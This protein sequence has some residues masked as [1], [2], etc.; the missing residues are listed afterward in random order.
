M[1][2]GQVLVAFPRHHSAIVKPMKFPPTIP[3]AAHTLQ[4]GILSFVSQPRMKQCAPS[5]VHQ[6]SVTSPF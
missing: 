4:S 5:Y 2:V 1:S 3:V 6:S